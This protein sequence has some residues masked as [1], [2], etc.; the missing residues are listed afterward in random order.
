MMN[1]SVSASA[2]QRIQ[3]SIFIFWK[4]KKERYT[5][6]QMRPRNLATKRIEEGR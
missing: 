2:E 4:C 1:Y 5:E 3:L 6:R